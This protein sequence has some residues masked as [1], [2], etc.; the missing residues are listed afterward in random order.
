MSYWN[1][2][3]YMQGVFWWD[4]S[5]NPNAGGVGDTGY[6]VQHKPAEAVLKKW[7]TDPAP[8]PT[9][10]A[11]VAFSSTGSSD[12]A[13]PSAGNAVALSASVKSIGSA[14][15]DAI[16]DIEVYDAANSKVFQRF[17]SAQQFA[18]DQTRAYTASW[19]P[20]VAGSY[21]MTIGVFTVDWSQN[22]HWNNQAALISVSGASHP[23]PLSNGKGTTD[24]WWPVNN[25][26]VSG[27]QPF[28]A[29]LEGF[30]VS[31]YKMYWQVDGGPLTLMGDSSVDYPHKESQVNVSGW[32][33]KGEGPY[34][35]QFTSKDMTGAVIGQKSVNIWVQ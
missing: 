34:T 9:P 12:P 19:T 30:S 31:Q 15:S 18:A 2:Y 17:F 7:F 28:K 5:S 16:V 21:R 27:T 6:T 1:D 26:G 22:Y 35:V 3:P 4:W 20:A 11:T 33:W 10:G 32:K 14:A 8:P 29:V 13:S 25:A 23:P 24:I